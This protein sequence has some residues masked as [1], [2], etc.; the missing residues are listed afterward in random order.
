MYNMNT[1]ITN[2][3]INNIIS[4]DICDNFYCEICC[5]EF[6]EEQNKYNCNN[7]DNKICD[8]CYTSWIETKYKNDCVYCRTPLEIDAEDEE[9]ANGEF[10]R[11]NQL[12]VTE[13]RTTNSRLYTCYIFFL[14]W[15][16]FVGYL[17]T[18]NN[19][20]LFIVINFWLG[21]VIN[22]SVISLVRLLCFAHDF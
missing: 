2:P 14:A 5:T 1:E 21:L 13:E 6:T 11:R 20:G 15:S 4:I 10:N 12:I 19:R 7:C 9:N 18:K 22:T 17:I 3:M 8:G 16:Y